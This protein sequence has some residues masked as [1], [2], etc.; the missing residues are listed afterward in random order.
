MDNQE[1]PLIENQEVREIDLPISAIF[2]DGER[3][4]YNFNKNSTVSDLISEITSDK[5]IEKPKD[6]TICVMYHGRILKSNEKF[7][8]IDSLP[9]YA[10]SVLFR[11][12]KSAPPADGQSAQDST[13]LRGFD[14]L[15]RMNLTQDQ[16]SELR[17]EFHRIRGELNMTEEERIEAEEEWLPSILYS[18]RDPLQIIRQNANIQRPTRRRNNYETF[19]FD[20]S[21][22]WTTF[23]IALVLGIVF[24]P[25]SLLSLLCSLQDK[26][27]ILGITMGVCV[28]YLLL[29]LFNVSIFPF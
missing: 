25:L 11:L 1:S 2:P 7:S 14:R 5:S 26:A 8:E 3:R 24:G 18:D 22:F 6:K 9:D 10:V 17:H 12:N 16:I 29:L 13:E 15:V 21:S 4:T 19:H 27:G 20:Q 23:F 28:H